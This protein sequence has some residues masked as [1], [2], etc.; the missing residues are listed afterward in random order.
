VRI[1]KLSE[2][3]IEIPLVRVNHKVVM[4]SREIKT[5]LVANAT[6]KEVNLLEA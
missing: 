6:V 2:T 4:Q 1:G 5:M 3:I